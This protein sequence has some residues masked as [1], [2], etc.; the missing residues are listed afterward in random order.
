MSASPEEQVQRMHR[1]A[2]ALV[3]MQE[4]GYLTREKIALNHHL[5]METAMHFQVVG[6]AAAA[7]ERAGYELGISIP[8]GDI[9]GLRNRVSHDYEGVN[10][11]ILEDI[12]FEDIPVL[13]SDLVVIMDERGI[14]REEISLPEDL[15]VE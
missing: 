11:N 15:Q 2:S 12:L 6:E 1:Y 4:S 10:W 9:V 7:L 8:V 5:Q 14:A 3:R 13:V